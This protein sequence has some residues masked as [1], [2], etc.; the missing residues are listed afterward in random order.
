M[1][2]RESKEF[3][4]DT[5]NTLSKD[6]RGEPQVSK[7]FWSAMQQLTSGIF[8]YLE[9]IS[10]TKEVLFVCKRKITFKIYETQK[11]SK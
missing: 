9:R 7:T 6:R 11:K 1:S 4:T 3:L 5:T 10:C 2:E 8:S